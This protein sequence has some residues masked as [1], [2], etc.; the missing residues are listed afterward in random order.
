MSG[1]VSLAIS[2]TFEDKYNTLPLLLKHNLFI[3]GSLA[4]VERWN[5]CP[6]NT[7]CKKCWSPHHNSLSCNKPPPP[8]RF[9]E[10]TALSKGTTVH[11]ATNARGPITL[12]PPVNTNAVPTAIN[13][14]TV[15]M[16]Q[17]ALNSLSCFPGPL[18]TH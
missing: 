14:T 13:T 16:T 6:K 12:T 2:F 18:P 1:K 11:I 10:N 5:D 3:F 9:A 7:Q 17:N 8:A 4:C 15:Q